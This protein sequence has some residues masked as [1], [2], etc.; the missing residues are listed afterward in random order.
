MGQLVEMRCRNLPETFMKLVRLA[1]RKCLVGGKKI[2]L[3]A[4][5]LVAGSMV[6]GCAMQLGSMFG[7]SSEGT[8]ASIEKPAMAHEQSLAM[9]A[10]TMAPAAQLGS[11]GGCPR[12]SIWQNGARVTV[13]K[14]GQVGDSLA[15]R[16]RGEITKTARECHIE[17]G[18]VTVKYGVAGRVL[19]GPVGRAGTIQLPLLVHVT[20]RKKQKIKTAKLNIRVKLPSDKPSG[21]FSA[22]QSL[23][24]PVEPGVPAGQYRLYVTFD[25]TGPGVGDDGETEREISI[26]PLAVRSL[27]S[28]SRSRRSA[29]SDA[30]AASPWRQ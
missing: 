15:I 13:Y 25:K 18:Q 17:A 21:N 27:M 23:S 7:Q 5:L 16:H 10:S 22:V 6:S 9:A 8:T 14:I 29:G 20:N 3:L 1:T 4:L 12:I 24:F 30:E 2:S 11:V 19:L 28:S 26:S